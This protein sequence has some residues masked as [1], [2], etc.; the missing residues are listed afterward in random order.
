[1]GDNPVPNGLPEG[2]Q[3]LL[4]QVD[5]AQIVMHETHDPDAL[6]D[7]L[8]AEFLPGQ[9]GGEVDLFAVRA[10]AAAA[11]DDIAIVQVI[12]G[13]LGRERLWERQPT[14]LDAARDR[15]HRPAMGIRARPLEGLRR[16]GVSRGHSGSRS[17]GMRAVLEYR[18][19]ATQSMQNAPK[20]RFH[21]AL[22][23]SIC[24]YMLMYTAAPQRVYWAK[25]T[26]TTMYADLI[27]RQA[28]TPTPCPGSAALAGPAPV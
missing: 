10:D 5:T 21:D 26:Y 2:A 19:K 15:A 16:G 17:R 12:G 18:W 7:L 11:G 3:S 27:N 6:I 8:D 14:Q 9:R 13:S 4:F 28:L 20:R 25:S 24:I 22:M 23:G 1:M